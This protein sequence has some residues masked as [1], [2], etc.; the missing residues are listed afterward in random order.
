MLVVCKRGPHSSTASAAARLWVQRSNSWL[1]LADTHPVQMLPPQQHALPLPLIRQRVWCMLASSWT[2]AVGRT[3]DRGELSPRQ[4]LST[5]TCCGRKHAVPVCPALLSAGCPC[6]LTHALC[7]VMSSNDS[8]LDLQGA[9]PVE[10]YT[11][12]SLDAGL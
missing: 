5:S 3:C 7:S 8:L 10:E 4:Q 6:P 11:V 1:H 2:S 9:T 12:P